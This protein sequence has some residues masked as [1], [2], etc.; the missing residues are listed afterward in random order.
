MKPLYALIAAAAAAGAVHYATGAHHI[1]RETAA[2]ADS[3]GFIPATMPD[4]AAQDTVLILAP[5]NC[6]HE[7]ARRADALAARLKDLGIPAVRSNQYS[8]AN[9]ARADRA[10]VDRTIDILKTN[11]VPVVF[12]NGKAAPNP[13]SDAVVAEYRQN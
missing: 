1:S 12:V 8:L 11:Q 3:N 13:D 10:S 9:I 4:G 2:L 6:P 5:L 7:G